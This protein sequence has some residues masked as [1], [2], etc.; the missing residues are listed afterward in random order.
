LEVSYPKKRC[1]KDKDK[2]LQRKL[3]Y[4]FHADSAKF[5]AVK[6]L[7]V[8]GREILLKKRYN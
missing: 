8:F 7:V 1:D 5:E 2:C 3:S 4:I 6:E